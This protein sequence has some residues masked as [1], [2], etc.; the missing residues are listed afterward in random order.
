M[1]LFTALF[2]LVPLLVSAQTTY[3]N[4]TAANNNYLG[5]TPYQRHQINQ[6]Q[7]L[8]AINAAAQESAS[9]SVPVNIAIMDP[10]ATLV[11][12]LHTDNAFPGSIDISQKKAKTVS[13]FNGVFTT[14]A[15]YNMTQPGQPL[16]AIEETNNGLIVFGGGLP[17][18]SEGFFIGSIGV[19]GG[20]TAQDI[21]IATAGVN[22]VGQIA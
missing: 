22:A 5:S 16:Y 11:A 15:L 17:I 20:S 18:F 19:S 4:N 14:E 12:F 3:P 2:A 13:L 21:Q 10:S 6:T 8:M 1:K 7:A 9:I